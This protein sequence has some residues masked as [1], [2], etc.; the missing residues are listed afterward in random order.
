MF[1]GADEILRLGV[2]IRE[3]AASTAGD[4]DFFA[5]AL[6]PFE[7]GYA[8]AALAGFDGTHQAR[9]TAADDDCV[10]IVCGSGFGHFCG[11]RHQG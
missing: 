7:D 1:V 2:E 8:L 3:I 11:V 9:G 4:Q 6:G 10:E 5:A